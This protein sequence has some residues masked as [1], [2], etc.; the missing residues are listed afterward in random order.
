MVTVTPLT[1]EVHPVQPAEHTL[2]PCAMVIFG[3]SGDLTRRKLVPALYQLARDG[4]LP[5]NFSLMGFARTA[6]TDESFRQSLLEGCCSLAEIGAVD[7]ALWRRFSEGIFYCRGE[8]NDPEAYQRLGAGLLRLDKERGGNGNRFFYLATPP[9]IYAQIVARLGAAGLAR[10]PEPNQPWTRIVVEKPFGRDYRTA[11]EL[12]RKIL[13]VFDEEQVYRIDHYLGKETVQN[14]LVFRLGNGIFEPIWNRRY[15]DHVQITVAETLG[16][17][18]RAAF[19]EQAGAA[20]DIVQ[21]HVMQLLAFV[22]MEPPATFQADAVR[23]EKVKVWR[24]IKPIRPEE[25]ACCTVRAQYQ[26]GTLNGRKVPGYREEP[27]VAPN[28]T[29]E[30]YA[31][32]R[33]AIDNWRWAG[34]PFYVRTGKRLGEWLTEIAIQFKYPPQLL[35]NRDASNPIAPNLLVLNIQPD[36][37]ISLRFEAK[38]PGKTLQTRPVE[39]QFSYRTSFGAQIRPAYA[40]LLLDCIRGDATLFSRRDGVEAT[41]A[42]MDPILEGWQNLG[43]P[44]LAEYEAGSWGPREADALLEA[45]GR[46]WRKP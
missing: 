39:M 33:F 1:S 40:T 42:L 5:A 16:V 34:V 17:E 8:S 12:N 29:T 45:E 13:E 35:F 22:A 6:M 28:S 3:A 7:T 24:S 19:Y 26:A 38:E 10:R 43:Q 44:P 4:L 46:Q 18:H 21:N 11:A 15:V 20:R 9:S 14:I 32:F 30:T 23:D 2:E 25:A 31:A 37:G 27:G 41:W 36:E